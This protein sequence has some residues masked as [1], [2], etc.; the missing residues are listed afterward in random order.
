MTP[1]SS[2]QYCRVLIYDSSDFE[3]IFFKLFPRIESEAANWVE[4]REFDI[5]DVPIFMIVNEDFDI[6]TREYTFKT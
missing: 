6:L 1:L 5:H 4:S 3:I 2:Y